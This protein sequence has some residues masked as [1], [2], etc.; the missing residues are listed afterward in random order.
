MSKGFRKKVLNSLEYYTAGLLEDTGFVIHAFTTRKGGVSRGS[1]A[2]LNLSILSSDERENVLENRRR[3]CHVLGIDVG[4]IV[5]ARQVHGDHVYRVDMHDRG[6]GAYDPATVVPDA[7]ALITNVSGIALTAFFADCVPVLFLDPVKKAVGLAHAG[8]KGTVQKI[9]AKTVLALT[10]QYGS[11][12]AHLLAAV[13]PS[14]GP[15]HYE[16]DLPVIEKV[17]C[18]FPQDYEQ[19][20][21]SRGKDGHAQLDLWQANVKQLSQAGVPEDNIAVAGMCTYCRQDV[22]FSHRGGMAGRQAALIM[23]K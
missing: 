10:Q 18:A 22:F 1:F 19:L 11:E 5:S 14:I 9:A 13:G 21:V 4:S 15:C 3:L 8:W 16:V 7:D 12:P 6:A 23:L 17:R 2:G 20:L